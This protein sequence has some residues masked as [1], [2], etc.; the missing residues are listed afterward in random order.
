MKGPYDWKDEYP[1]GGVMG[2]SDDGREEYV[3]GG[4]DNC[5]DGVDGGENCGDGVDGGSYAME[6]LKWTRFPGM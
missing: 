5:G 2:P 1:D 4:V 6:E 3:S